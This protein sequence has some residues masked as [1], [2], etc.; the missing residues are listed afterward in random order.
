MISCMF[1]K[2]LLAQAIDSPHFSGSLSFD[3]TIYEYV[4]IQCVLLFSC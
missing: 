2:V 1:F 3:N 4:H